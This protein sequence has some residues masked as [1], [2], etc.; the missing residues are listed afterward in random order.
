MISG[1]ILKKESLEFIRILLKLR[2]FTGIL[3]DITLILINLLLIFL[4]LQNYPD[5]YTE[6]SQHTK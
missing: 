5:I 3:K 6:N 4:N 2:Y 1:I